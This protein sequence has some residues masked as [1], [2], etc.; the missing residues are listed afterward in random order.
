[1]HLWF[2]DDR[3]LQFNEKARCDKPSFVRSCA[4]YAQTNDEHPPDHCQPPLTLFSLAK[5]SMSHG[6]VEDSDWR[7]T[8][9]TGVLRSERGH[10]VVGHAAALMNQFAPMAR[11]NME[12]RSHYTWHPRRRC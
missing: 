8:D 1:M 5:R 6:L 11:G 10:R 2:D 9:P 3:K 12:D 4:V 7:G